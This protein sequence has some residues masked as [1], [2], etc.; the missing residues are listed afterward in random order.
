MYTILAQNLNLGDKVL[1]FN[2]LMHSFIDFVLVGRHL[3]LR[4]AI[5]D[6]D[7]IGAKTDGGTAA[8]HRGETTTQDNDP[9]ANVGR[10]TIVGLCQEFDTIFDPFEVRARYDFVVGTGQ[11][12]GNIATSSE[13]NCIV[14]VE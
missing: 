2:M 1:E 12:I 4:A 14:V 10:L 8:V 6:I 5:Q 3:F 9:L 13:L 11:G 7:L